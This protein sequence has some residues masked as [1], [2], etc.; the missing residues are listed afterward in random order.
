MRLM[1]TQGGCYNTYQTGACSATFSD[2]DADFG[3]LDMESLHLATNSPAT[4]G[5]DNTYSIC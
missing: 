5:F 2:Y 4:T 3:G 1:L